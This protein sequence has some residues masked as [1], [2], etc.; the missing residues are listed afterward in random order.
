M[1]RPE[2]IAAG[3]E[4]RVPKH[5]HP[6]KE[7]AYRK[8]CFRASTSIGVSC[9][10]YGFF[11]SRYTEAWLSRTAVIHVFKP[12]AC[13]FHQGVELVVTGI[14]S[15]VVRNPV[16]GRIVVPFTDCIVVRALVTR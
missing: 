15:V 2:L 4:G 14:V 5:P 13:N 16:I 6:I 7:Q 9:R 11:L 12:C 10:G 3:M 8:V 1:E